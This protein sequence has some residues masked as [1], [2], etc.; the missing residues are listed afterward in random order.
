MQSSVEKVYDVFT[1][2]VA[3]GRKMKQSDVDSIGQGRVWSGKDALRLGLVDRIGGINDAIKV[4][5]RMAKISKYRIS[6][7][8][9]QKEPFMELMENLKDE[10]QTS[11]IKKEFGD[12]YIYYK[13]LH[14]LNKLKGILAWMPFEMRAE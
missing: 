12:S 1:K 8:P 9:E 11:F 3:D 13:N 14:A 10:T 4:A 6:S 2:R 5:A 7:Q